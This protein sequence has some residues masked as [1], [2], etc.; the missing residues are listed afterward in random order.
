MLPP[1]YESLG[2]THEQMSR[3]CELLQQ[4]GF[5]RGFDEAHL[6]QTLDTQDYDYRFSFTYALDQ[7]ALGLVMPEAKIS[8]CLYPDHWQ[9]NTLAE[10]QYRSRQLA[11]QMHRLSKHYAVFMLGLT[12]VVMNTKH[13]IMLRIG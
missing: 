2:V 5:V 7:L 3:A 1:L 12:V 13:V 10:K 4:A 11:W 8:D 6:Q 9:N